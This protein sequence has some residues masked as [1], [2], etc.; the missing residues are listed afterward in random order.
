M[1]NRKPVLSN[2]FDWSKPVPIVA[3]LDLKFNI[4]TYQR[5]YRWTE[6]HIND[7]LN[8]IQNFIDSFN[9]KGIG[10]DDFYS[11][12]PIVVKWNYEK[13]K[14]N[15]IDGQQRMT[16]ISLVIKFFNSMGSNE[17]L[18]QIEYETREKSEVYLN[19]LE[20][21]TK[22]PEAE[23]ECYDSENKLIHYNENIDFKYMSRAFAAINKWFIEKGRSFNRN[24]FQEIFLHNTRVIWYELPDGEDETESFT[25]LNLGKIP[26]T[27]AELIK[28]LFLNSSN[29]KNDETSVNEI[30]LEQIKIAAE[31][32][33]IENTLCND[34]F[35]L[36]IHEIDYNKPNRIDFIFDLIVQCNALS[37]DLSKAN[38]G[39]D[40]NRTFRYFS[41]F[42]SQTKNDNSDFSVTIKENWKKVKRYF[43]IFEEWFNNL[44]VYHYV[45]YITEIKK[46]KVIPDLISLWNQCEQTED[47]VKELK[48]YIKKNITKTINLEQLYDIE[49]ADSEGNV[50]RYPKKTNARPIF[51]LHNILTIINQ[52]RQLKN[53][54]EYDE[55]VFYKFPFH[56]FQKE[57]WDVEHI[58]SNTENPLDK[59][60]DQ[61]EWIAYS[62]EEITPSVD[63]YESLKKDV[64]KFVCLDDKTK[65]DVFNPMFSALKDKI[66]EQVIKSEG[67]HNESVKNQIGNFALLDSK[68]NS[69]YGNALFPTKRRWIIGKD[70]GIKYIVEYG[71]K[72]DK[73]YSINETKGEIAFVPP[74]T[75]QVFLKYYTAAPN[76]YLSWCKEDFDSYKQNMERLFKE[77]GFI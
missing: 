69:G 12:Q 23:P 28:A 22:N 67:L 39:N 15:L 26:L 42:F 11:L 7:L 19:G 21:D 32:D 36:F 74:V 49:Y 65:E 75:K 56:L 14:W 70:Q 64:K 33:R 20:I 52:N 68:T 5:G 51:L 66:L 9:G 41:E 62:F 27:N 45:G 16:S 1:K 63:K 8:D 60:K 18:P 53:K 4:P 31:W 6:T 29:F 59:L 13:G 30:R 77:E 46:S 2:E 73:G 37:I 43:Q 3:L 57:D 38:L 54:E 25:R 35:W 48:T 10:T 34:E 72:Y 24:K 76:D 61:K 17:E 50:K 44:E 47:F 55:R 71:D 58:D 40:E